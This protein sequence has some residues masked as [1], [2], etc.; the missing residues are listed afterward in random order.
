MSPIFNHLL[1]PYI[2]A[3]F[4]AINMGGSG[5]APGF[6]VAYGA[7]II[8]KSLIPGL[9]GIMVFLGAIL[10]GKNTAITIGK[11]LLLAELLN[12]SLVS[13]ILFSVSLSLLFA[14]LL[15]IPQSTS[16]ATI[17]AVTAPALYLGKLNTSKLFFEI[18]PTWFILPILSFFICYGIGR[19]IYKPIRKRGYFLSG[20]ISNHPSLKVLIIIMALYVSFSIGA[21][22]VANAAGPIASMTMNELGIHANESN[23]ILIMMLSTLIVAPNFGIGSSFFGHKLVKNTGKEII[24]F[25]KIEAIII[26]FVT[27]SLLLVASVTKGIPTSLVQLNVGAI[28]GIG[29]AKL[30]AKNIFRRT[31]VN[32][33]FVVWLIA[34][35]IAFS[36]AYLLTYALDQAGYLQV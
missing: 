22:N 9:F 24:L 27:A 11:G 14:N 2:I 10:A 20:T 18:I 12:Y 15:G 23:F 13:V 1:I 36:L 33:F 4:L 28:L 3:M 8:K 34:P 31:Q 26:A 16:Q 32:N 29:V 5:T 35:I 17:L 6:S 7:N 19:F 25:G 21:N 30:G